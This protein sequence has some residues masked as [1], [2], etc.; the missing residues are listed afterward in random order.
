MSELLRQEFQKWKGY[1]VPGFNSDG[2]IPVDYLHREFVA[3][4]AG[5]QSAPERCLESAYKEGWEAGWVDRNVDS[6]NDQRVS[7]WLPPKQ[8]ILDDWNASLAKSL[9][10]APPSV[11]VNT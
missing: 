10:P 2:Q 6:N 1:Q 5:R 7:P 9:L 11:E 4:C 8:Q 3:F